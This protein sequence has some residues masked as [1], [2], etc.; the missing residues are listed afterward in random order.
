MTK[1]A[2]IRG[3]VM[4]G[5]MLAAPL[6][7]A[8]NAK[9]AATPVG[10]SWSAEVSPDG[11]SGI[12]LDEQQTKDIQS[13]SDYFNH[14]KTLKGK[15]V[16]TAADGKVMKGKFMMMRPGKFRFDYDRPSR[17]LIIS[18]GTY[19]AIQDLDVSTE[20]RV[21]LDQTP[22][23]ILL[24]DDVDLLRDARIAEVQTIGDQLLLTLE[25][26]S[27]DSSGKITLI[28]N[29]AP[30]LELREWITTDAQGLDTRIEVV[31]SVR[32]EAVDAANFVITSVSNP[33]KR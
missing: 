26:K 28:M 31:G 13:V 19:L 15:F 3:A 9:D 18:D 1:A 27:P 2:F 10:P 8:Q 4:L 33:F 14:L 17:Q 21:A 7:S 11:S 25:D 12:A 20:D 32:D 16:Q 22:F 23:R 24:R 5:F 30:A 29:K 6:A